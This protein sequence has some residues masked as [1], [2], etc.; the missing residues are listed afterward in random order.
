M[1]KKLTFEERIESKLLLDK[2]S[3]FL[4]DCTSPKNL[5]LKKSLLVIDG[6]RAYKICDIFQGEI[7]GSSENPDDPELRQAEFYL[8][9]FAETLWVKTTGQKIEL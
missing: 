3:V 2:K 8:A 5:N 7:S 6:K 1:T 9:N 4:F